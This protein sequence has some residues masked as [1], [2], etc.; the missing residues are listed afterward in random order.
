MRIEIKNL[1]FCI[2]APKEI[3]LRVKKTAKIYS[4]KQFLSK[5][6]F[7]PVQSISLYN[8]SGVILDNSTAKVLAI[9]SPNYLE[10]EFPEKPFKSA[11]GKIRRN[12]NEGLLAIF[13]NEVKNG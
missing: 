4:V 9:S 8:S 2:H 7:I 5:S 12:D 1:S 13:I 3:I 10:V 6:F 11:I